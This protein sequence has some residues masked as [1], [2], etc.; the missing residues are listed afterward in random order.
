MSTWLPVVLLVVA[1]LLL[2]QPGRRPRPGSGQSHV[3]AGGQPLAEPVRVQERAGRPG[4]RGR[5][6]TAG[7]RAAGTRRSGGERSRAAGRPGDAD[8]PLGAALV[9]VAARLRTGM[10]VPRA[11]RTTLAGQPGA[12]ATLAELADR[13]PAGPRADAVAGARTAVAVADQLGAPVA[14]VL[15]CCAQGLAEA[16]EG[17]GQRRSAMAAPRATARLL[18]WLPLAGLGLGVLLGVDPLVV[19]ADGGLGTASLLL[20]LLLMLLG[21]R[22]SA[23]LVGRAQR[24]GS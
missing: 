7:R 18:A 15:E 13:L 16:E 4:A 6:S 5:M 23:L 22:W 9:E 24:A 19:F 17:A 21:R 8:L 20:G 2:A 1:G 14:D 12:P 11:W 3:G 10:D